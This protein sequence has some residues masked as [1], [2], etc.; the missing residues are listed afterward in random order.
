MQLLIPSGEIQEQIILEKENVHKCS[1]F[2][3]DHI[4]FTYNGQIIQVLCQIIDISAI[5]S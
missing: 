1:L 5:Q 3:S 4:A 2:R